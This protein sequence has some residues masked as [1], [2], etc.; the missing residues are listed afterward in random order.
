MDGVKLDR[1][2]PDL[3]QR[4]VGLILQNRGQIA[5]RRRHYQQHLNGR[6]IQRFAQAEAVIAH[7]QI[8]SQHKFVAHDF[9]V[10]NRQLHIA[11]S[12]R[13]IDWTDFEPA[14]LRAAPTSGTIAACQEFTIRR[15]VLGAGERLHLRAGEQPR[16]LSLVSGTL[17]ATSENAGGSRPP[18]ALKL[19]RGD[20][21]IVPYAGTHTF[22]AET[23]AIL[24][25]T[26]NFAG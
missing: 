26:E 15:V 10:L 16:L 2:P 1:W 24:L 22:T 13:S 14:P 3:F 5:T 8:A 23:T 17:R 12:L 11:Q 4:L 9:F 20:N 21:T 18:A 19:E 25:I 6:L 7:G